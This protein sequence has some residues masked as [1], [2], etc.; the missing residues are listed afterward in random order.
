MKGNQKLLL[1]ILF[2]SLIL[3]VLNSPSAPQTQAYPSA[4]PFGMHSRLIVQSINCLYLDSENESGYLFQCYSEL[5]DSEQNYFEML[6]RAQV[7]YDSSFLLKK[8]HYWDPNRK[9][10]YLGD[11]SAPYHAQEHFAAAVNSYL[12]LEGVSLNKSHAYYELGHVIHLIQDLTV[13]FHAHNDPFEPHTTY[14]D[15]CY[16]LLCDNKFILTTFGNYSVQR[17]W[18]GKINAGGWVHQ[19]AL[20]AYPYYWTIKSNQT[21]ACWYPIAQKLINTA[22]SLVAGILFYFWQYVHDID[23]D[24]DGLNA[25]AEQYYNTDYR[26]ND[27]DRDLILDYEETVPGADGFITDPTSSDTDQDGYSDYAEIFDYFTNPIDKFDNPYYLVPFNCRKF[28]GLSNKRNSIHFYWLQPLN[29]LPGWYYKIFLVQEQQAP[30]LIYN[31]TNR[32]FTFNLPNED[33][34]YSFRLYCYK[35]E[36]THGIYLQWSGS[37]TSVHPQTDIHS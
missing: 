9:S 3:S 6:S 4:Y 20:L 10:G 28:V 8:G 2:T 34:F 33:S 21:G 19:A 13:P 26:S 24:Q 5:R 1:L 31:G 14:E 11:L 12:G 27:T 16:R 29:F 22:I 23:F 32:Y 18:Q 35:N 36:V 17:D 37:L 30:L 25:T 15:Y 7:A